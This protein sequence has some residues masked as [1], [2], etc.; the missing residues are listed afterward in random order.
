MAM[1]GEIRGSYPTLVVQGTRSEVVIF[2]LDP[3]NSVQ[4]AQLCVQAVPELA[5]MSTAAGGTAQLVAEA[6]RAGEGAV[7]PDLL[8][9]LRGAAAA[10]LPMDAVQESQAQPPPPASETA[11]QTVVRPLLPCPVFASQPRARVD[12]LSRPDVKA[13]ECQ[14]LLH[15]C[16]ERR[17]Q[18]EPS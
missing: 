15:S 12:E 11:Q 8:Q 14:Q 6:L 7:R 16:T 13:A 9:A 18:Q 10:V 1:A 5:L 3:R 17:K 2:S 4:C